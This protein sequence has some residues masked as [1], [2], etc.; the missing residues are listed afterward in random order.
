MVKILIPTQFQKIT[1]SGVAIYYIED[2]EKGFDIRHILSKLMA[3]YPSLTERLLD[4]NAQLN[5]F[6]NIFVNDEDIRFLNGED[7]MLQQGDI[8]SLIPAIAGG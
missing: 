1:G 4:K 7:T 6:I 3:D 8:I 2:A 5:K